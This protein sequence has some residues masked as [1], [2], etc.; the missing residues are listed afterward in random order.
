MLCLVRQVL[1]PRERECGCF[2]YFETSGCRLS[3]RD[4]LGKPQLLVPVH[5]Y[6]DILR[7]RSEYQKTLPSPDS[8]HTI[9]PCWTKRKPLQGLAIH[10]RDSLFPA[11]Y[12]YCCPTVGK[13]YSAARLL[14]KRQTLPLSLIPTFQ[15]RKIQLSNKQVWEEVPI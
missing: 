4:P 9:C 6:H 12:L 11:T 2:D 3:W 7:S 5:E 15:I 1:Q 8:I 13:I 14:A 10:W